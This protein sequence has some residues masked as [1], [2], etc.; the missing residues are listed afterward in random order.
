MQFNAKKSSSYERATSSIMA[1][2]IL[3]GFFFGFGLQQNI[4]IKN[5]QKTRMAEL[6]M[7]CKNY[8]KTR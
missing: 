5:M 3:K 8:N 4:T 1:N 7:V 2:P 6:T